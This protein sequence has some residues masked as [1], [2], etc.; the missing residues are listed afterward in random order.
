M[1]RSDKRQVISDKCPHKHQVL[2]T[3][4]GHC[5]VAITAVFCVD[6]GKQLT[7]AKVEV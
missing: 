2:R 6:C 5:T 7:E 4:E 3:I 1:K